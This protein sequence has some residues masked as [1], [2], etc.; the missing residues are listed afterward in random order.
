[1]LHASKFLFSGQNTPFSLTVVRFGIDNTLGKPILSFCVLLMPL[2]SQPPQEIPELQVGWKPGRKQQF[3]LALGYTP[4]ESLEFWGCSWI[5]KMVMWVRSYCFCFCF[6]LVGFFWFFL[7]DV[8]LGLEEMD[9][10][11]LNKSR[12][13][14]RSLKSRVSKTR[15]HRWLWISVAAES[16]STDSEL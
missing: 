11:S 16:W 10:D 13:P 8:S 15:A 3:L 2:D 12:Q 1:M 4:L 9:Q 7:L 5:Q 6:C 14:P